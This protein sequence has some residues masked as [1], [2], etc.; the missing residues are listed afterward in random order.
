LNASTGRH[1]RRNVEGVVHLAK[2]RGI[3]PV[4]VT[5]GHGRFHSS[6]TRHNERLRDVARREG[7][8]LVDFEKL[9]RDPALFTEDQVHLTDEGNRALAAAV[10]DGLLASPAFRKLVK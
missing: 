1:A 5:V 4:L 10:A 6:L 9:G 2:G 8:A 3:L 7:A